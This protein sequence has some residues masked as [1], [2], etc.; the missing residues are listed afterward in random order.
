MVFYSLPSGAEL[1]FVPE[2]SVAVLGYFDGVHRGHRALFRAAAAVGGAVLAWTFLSGSRT[3]LLTDD[4]DRF[5]LLG[6]AGARYAAAEDFEKLRNEDGSSF[7]KSVLRDA[8]RVSHVVC[9]ESFRFGKGAA[10]DAG[11]LY[12]L[13]EKRGIGCTVVPEK[14]DDG[15]PIS[16]SEIR[17]RLSSGD[18]EGAAR[19]L[20]RPHFYRLPVVRG[21]MLG[22]LIGFPTANQIVPEKLLCPAEGVYVC[23]ASFEEDGADLCFPGVLNIGTCPTLDESGLREFRRENPGYE[24]PDGVIL[25]SKVMETHVIGFDGDLYGRVLRVDLFSRLRGEI[26]FSGTDELVRAV[27][28]DEAAALEYFKKTDK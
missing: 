26:R 25:G 5:R 15:V 9:G 23:R 16:S 20:G 2:G 7:V 3:G 4:E 14:K 13:C 1:S 18:A 22:R 19:L 17:K 12:D 21:K 6:E 27:R 10:W 24:L 28:A 8:L 11:D